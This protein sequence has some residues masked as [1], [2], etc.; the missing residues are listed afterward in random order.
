MS[1]LKSYSEAR[2]ELEKIASKRK[3]FFSNSKILREELEQ[4]KQ[5]GSSPSPY[6]SPAA[7]REALFG[8]VT[9]VAAVTSPFRSSGYGMGVGSGGSSSS[10]RDLRPLM[11]S[12]S[13]SVPSK[14]PY[15]GGG[16]SNS[17]SSSS[18]HAL[19]H[20][21]GSTGGS[22]VFRG[23]LNAS[24]VDV[25]AFASSS[26]PFD[27]A[28]S[29]L[30]GPASSVIAAFRQLQAKARQVEQERADALRDRDELRRQH[31][32]NLRTQVKQQ[33]CPWVNRDGN[34]LIMNDHTHIHI[35]IS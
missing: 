23:P 15:K 13:P 22:S 25:D 4:A 7:G 16:N 35:H 31:E 21:F 17:S 1:T 11:S 3:Q 2:R 20:D 8:S 18:N 30:S 26:A 29:V 9:S 12:P 34:L 24:G 10:S 5:A 28:S 6:A 19:L 33:E 32:A 14:T 27:T